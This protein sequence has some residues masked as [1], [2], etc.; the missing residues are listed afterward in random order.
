MKLIA[1]SEGATLQ[2][3][4]RLVVYV[5]AA[6]AVARRIV[7]LIEDETPQ[8]LAQPPREAPL[9]L[10]DR[11]TAKVLAV[12]LNEVEGAQDDLGIVAGAAVEHGEAAGEADPAGSYFRA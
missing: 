10:L 7:K 9:A 4:V 6:V 5:T 11:S 8:R 3:S 12:E 1:E 2:D